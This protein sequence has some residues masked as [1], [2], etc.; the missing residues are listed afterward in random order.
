M[1][2]VLREV[3]KNVFREEEAIFELGAESHFL[4]V[5]VDILTLCSKVIIYYNQISLVEKLQHLIKL[6]GQT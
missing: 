1:G 6:P 5:S 4:H 2:N 3:P